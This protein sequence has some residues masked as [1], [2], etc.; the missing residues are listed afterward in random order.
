MI[1]QKNLKQLFDKAVEIAKSKY[2][3]DFLFR[4][5]EFKNISITS[6]GLIEIN[7]ITRDGLYD[8][9]ENEVITLSPEELKD[10]DIYLPLY[11]DKALER[12]IFKSV[13]DRY[14]MNRSKI[15]NQFIKKEFDEVYEKGFQLEI[16]DLL[17]KISVI[18]D[19]EY[20]SKI[21]EAYELGE[22]IEDSEK[23]YAKNS[24]PA[25]KV[26]I[27]LLEKDY[28]KV[29]NELTLM[30]QDNSLFIDN[31]LS[32]IRNTENSYVVE[33]LKNKYIQLNKKQ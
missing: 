6:E 28:E 4:I 7:F 2:S 31:L 18:L 3:K 15:I 13:Y 11:E 33:F 14:L 8:I 10:S 9:M 24:N 12:H 19:K 22:H 25:I 26:S 5:K 17:H 32:I 29:Q 23:E 1:I 27:D 16:L 21:D 20:E 30:E